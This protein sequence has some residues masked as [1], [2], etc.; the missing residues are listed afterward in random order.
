MEAST[1]QW[2]IL[3]QLSNCAFVVMMIAQVLD[4]Y[5]W[6]LLDDSVMDN[7]AANAAWLARRN[8]YDRIGIT[9]AALMVILRVS[10]WIIEYFYDRRT[11]AREGS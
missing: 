4:W 1:F 7:P 8:I 9:S 6:S 5:H 11:I 10:Y 3:R 2:R